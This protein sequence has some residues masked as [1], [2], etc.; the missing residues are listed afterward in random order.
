[1]GSADTRE[2]HVIVHFNVQTTVL[3]SILWQTRRFG[4]PII[5][6]YVIQYVIQMRGNGSR[7]ILVTDVVMPNRKFLYSRA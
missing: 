5:F 7:C 3:T 4:I 6:T 2:N 1:V